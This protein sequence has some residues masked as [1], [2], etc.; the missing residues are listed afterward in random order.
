[1]QY[2]VSADSTVLLML[3]FIFKEGEHTTSTRATAHKI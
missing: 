3:I 1:M 2:D